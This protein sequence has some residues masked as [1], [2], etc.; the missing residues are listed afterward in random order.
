MFMYRR[1]VRNLAILIVVFATALA[2]LPADTA[3]QQTCKAADGHRLAGSLERAQK[4]YESVKAADGDQSCAVEG[5]RLV[6]RAR[7]EAAELVTAGQLAIRSGNLGEAA[8]KFRQALDLDAGS[9]AAAAGIAQVADLKSRPL[10]TAVS[11]GNR[12][13]TDWV[14]PVGRLAM[15]AAIGLLVLYALSGLCSR[16]LV[17]VD[18]V[19]WTACV[20]RAAGSLGLVL[21]IVASVM[22]PLFAMFKPFRPTWT[23]CWIGAVVLLVVGVVAVGLVFKGARSKAW[24][25]WRALLLALGV[26]TAAGCVLGW[27]ACVGAYDVRLMLV[28]IA[29]VSI[30]VLLT[31]AALG[32]NLRLQ[33]EVQQADGEVN[34]ASSDYLLAR[35]KDLGT[36][37]PALHQATSAPGNRTPLSQIPVEELSALPAG[38]VVGALSRLFFALR[39]DL[40]WRARVTLVDDNRAATTLSRNGQHAAS[41]VFSRADLKLP[42]DSD[43]DRAR[44]QMLT[45][46]AAFILVHLSAVHQE[47]EDGLYGARQWRSVALQVIARSRS[48]LADD[49]TRVATRVQLLAKA[50][51]EDPGNELARFEYLW[52]NYD[53]QPFAE[54][55]FEAFTRDI[56][57]QF[58]RSELCQVSDDKEGWMPLK[59]RVLYS[60]ATQLLNAYTKAIAGGA[61]ATQA[62]PMLTSARTSATELNRLCDSGSTSWKRKELCRQQAAM[63]PYALNLVDCLDALSDDVTPRAK[64]GQHPHD[65]VSASPRLA[66]DH[67]CL[68]MFLA[69]RQDLEEHDRSQ[70]RGYALEDLRRALVTEADKENARTDPCFANLRSDQ[71]FLELVGPL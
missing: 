27:T 25:H 40:T 41:A 68:H 66:Y 37:T 39:P 19:A 58:T 71:R 55:D 34:A 20:R 9:A 61:T 47:L 70:Q 56:D 48:L 24:E 60:S 33:V 53:Q 43:S 21:L 6:A 50:V 67:A 22:T 49:E 15:L 2:A 8:D 7:Q 57:Q 64:A 31:A 69:Q 30:G 5:R 3:A 10:P 45:G 11:N 44:A 17:K 26:V 42:A 4:L 13:Y 52:A 46:A 59:I 35:M 23:Q 63:Q 12:F 65:S 18:A 1:L 36:E 51:D 54:T 32:Q 16:M 14:L 38:K 29:L 62:A 28:H